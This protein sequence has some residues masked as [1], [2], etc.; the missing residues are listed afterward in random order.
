MG[1]TRSPSS[2]T[3]DP[4]HSH[5]THAQQKRKSSKSS[6]EELHDLD[7]SVR[8]KKKK[9]KKER[10]DSYHDDED[11]DNN[12]E[13]PH[14]RNGHDAMSSQQQQQVQKLPTIKISLRLPSN[15]S[16]ISP[17]ATSPSAHKSSSTKKKRRSSEHI[18]VDSEEDGETDTQYHRRHHRL[19][20]HGFSDDD[21]EARL[22]SSHKKKKKHKHKHKHRHPK[23][24]EEQVEEQEVEERAEQTEQEEWDLR[25]TADE[26][27]HRGNGEYN[28]AGAAKITLRLGKE[29]T[30][31]QKPSTTHRTHNHPLDEVYKPEQNRQRKPSTKSKARSHSRSESQSVVGTPIDIKQEEV[32]H[33]GP[34]GVH[35]QIGQKRP[36][37]SLVSRRS[38][39]Q[40][41]EMAG[42]TT[43]GIDEDDLDDPL[44]GELDDP[45]DEDEE[46]EDE[47]D[48]DEDNQN[49]G[50][51]S[52]DDEM[53]SPTVD[54][55]MQ[56]QFG[57][58]SVKSSQ[59]GSKTL[60]GS[61]AAKPPKAKKSKASK[62]EPAPDGSTATA[63]KAVRKGK[64]P[65]RLLT[66]KSTTP[67]VPKKKELSVVCHKLL[68]N[69]IRKDMY[70]LFSEPVDPTLVPDY[71]TVI[72]NPMDFS[73]MRAKVERN[74]YPN[75]DEFLKDF[76]LVCDN[77]R[78]YNSKD[79]LYWKQADKLWEWG[80]KAIER[81]RKSVLDKDEELLRAV[82]DEETVDV[83]GMGDYSNNATPS[84]NR[85]PL[86]SADS[87]ADSPMPF[88]DAGRSHTPQQYRKTKKI[89]HRRDGTIAF[90]Y[91]TDGSI[92]P[93]SHPDPWSL[94]PVVQDFGSAPLVCPL[95]ETNLLYNGQ[96]LDD[97]P[98]W[99]APTSGFRSAAYLDYGPYAILGKP[100]SDAGSL[101]GVQNIPAY[102]GMVFGDE[103]GEAYVRSLAMF[104]DGIVDEA[105]LA[106]MNKADTLGLL[107]VKE[108]V[109]KKVET[110]TRGA[111][112][113]VDKVAAVIREEKSGQPSEVDT[114]VPLSL[115]QQNF[116]IEKATA[117]DRRSLEQIDTME[118]T[119][120]ENKNI[121]ND[122]QNRLSEGPRDIEMAETKGDAMDEVESEALDVVKNEVEDQAKDRAEDK[123]KDEEMKSYEIMQQ[124]YRP[125][126]EE[127]KI[128][129]PVSDGANNTTEQPAIESV[130]IR[131]VI[132]DIQAWPKV[133]REKTD[134]ETWK[135]LKIEL[136]SLLPAS[137]R[138]ASASAS[139]TSAQPSTASAD[140]IAIKWGQSWA[141]GNSEE[142]KKWVREYLEQNSS[143][144][145]QIVQL[146]AA[147]NTGQ[148]A[149]LNSTL[150]SAVASPAVASLAVPGSAVGS[151][152][153][154][155]VS[156][157]ATSTTAA[158][159]SEEQ[160]KS[161][162]EQ[163]TKS[164]RRRLA[165]MVQY[166]PL[167]E[168][169]PQ[170]L[171]PP[172]PPTSTTAST[173]APATSSPTP[174]PLPIPA[175]AP[176]ASAPAPAS[177][178]TQSDAETSQAT[179][180]STPSAPKVPL[181]ST[182]LATAS[183]TVTAASVRNSETV[184]I[185]ATSSVTD[186]FTPSM[187]GT[188]GEGSTS[189]L[190]SPG[191]SSP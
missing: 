78:L 52:D 18:S 61:A 45:E 17:T 103:K 74:F 173:S 153:T 126:E 38:E 57:S 40:D 94:V 108:Y 89:K 147:R 107:E 11:D 118:N 100:P 92:D 16:I 115:W 72:K 179:L 102:T 55:R 188:P 34:D 88:S 99:K 76:Q 123:S 21:Q 101:S 24:E 75:I 26:D 29:T 154:T 84:H 117:D 48:E 175:P 141:G 191:S 96:Y 4:H 63:S 85:A 170:R 112:T 70:V 160:E 60:P 33:H 169:N 182:P 176:S 116:D 91:S 120:E 155:A 42:Q 2:S 32:P 46:E 93:A 69:F 136:D 184:A 121:L 113:I 119:L 105:E 135:Q 62:S 77:A 95:V 149:I 20:G 54:P 82:K 183:A 163:M 142:S 129:H 31:S 35:A 133:L 64:A 143:E 13:R 68:D 87:A 177:S 71:S 41:T 178:K 43:E 6:P 127:V 25:D 171:P 166:V 186:A 145:Q 180:S 22:S 146:L 49:G 139:T 161:L 140:D 67:A 174:T 157:P 83:G 158:M 125:E 150:P 185:A 3:L 144:M 165:E 59:L 19:S 114:R 159:G 181:D 23:H 152:A 50:D 137:Q 106:S 79:T 81:E 148:M 1:S 15:P 124:N 109:R 132:L 10:H 190:S 39:S 156:T 98:Y 36:F 162:V 104:L 172:A 151:P 5:Y 110:L 134:Y 73:T 168:I 97:Y 138:S 30:K 27:H 66:P 58:K 7:T 28:E 187:P 56:P 53:M 111:S 47:E 189:S 167:S 14:H 80:S 86:L 128:E 37:A 122:S 8:K 90:T 12:D 164:I 65:K 9:S 131:Q 130:D 51:R 44:I